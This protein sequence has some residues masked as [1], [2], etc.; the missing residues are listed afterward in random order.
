MSQQVDCG[1]QTKCVVTEIFQHVCQVWVR[2]PELIHSVCMWPCSHEGCVNFRETNKICPHAECNAEDPE[3]LTYTEK[4][5]L[6]GLVV[7]FCH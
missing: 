7:L 5:M 6:A 4:W 3:I 2:N 1:N